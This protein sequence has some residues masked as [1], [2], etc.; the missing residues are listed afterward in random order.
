LFGVA[1]QPVM[2]LPPLMTGVALGAACQITEKL[3]DPESDGPN[4]H[5][6][7]SGYVPSRRLTT[8]LPVML[9]LMVRTFDC[10]CDKLHGALCVQ[11]VPLPAGEAH[12]VVVAADAISDTPPFGGASDAQERP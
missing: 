7:E 6:E 8:T 11:A 3:F 9:P 10:A 5:V 4:V 12:R 1:V 2:S